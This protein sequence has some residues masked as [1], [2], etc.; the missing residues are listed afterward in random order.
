LLCGGGESFRGDHY[1]ILVIDAPEDDMTQQWMRD[2]L[3]FLVDTEWKAI[4]DFDCNEH[5][6]QFFE[7]TGSVVKITLCDEFDDMSDFNMQN[8]NQLQRL[9]DDIQHSAKQPSWIFVNGRGAEQSYSLSQWNKKRA[10]GFKKAVHFFSSEF[11]P[12]RTTVVFLLFSSD[13]SDILL[14]AVDEFCTLFPDQWMCVVQNDDIRQKLTDSV[15]ESDERIVVGMPWC[16]I[17]ES[18]ARL[19]TPE[20]TRACEIPTS[21]GVRVTL[22]NSMLNRLPDIEV[23]GCSEC[24]MDY[25]RCDKQE[26]EKL[27]KT[28][29]IKFYRGE[30]PTWWNFWFK[31]QVCEREIHNDLSRMVDRALRSSSDHDFV[32]RVRVY[33][34]PGAGGTTS[35][36]HILWTLRK[37]YRV[38]IIRICSDRLSSE[39]I[40]QLV[41]QIMEYRNYKE[42]A[43][44]NARPV[45]LL[46]DNP[47]EETES[48]LLSETNERA[49]SMVKPGDQHGV[50]CVFLEC[51]HLT[52]I[53]TSDSTNDLNY[54]SLKHELS[55][56]EIAWFNDK[57]QTLQE[58]F[59]ARMANSVNPE[60]LISFN[61]LKSNFN[62]DFISKTVGALVDAITSEKERTLLK[63]I[64]LLNSFD[65]RP[66]P[67]AAFDEMMSSG[68]PF[69]Q[70]KKK[71]TYSHWENE[72]SD[73]FRV[74][75][76]LKTTTHGTQGL[77]NTNALLA[78]ES[79]EAL[80]NTSTGKETI[81]DT[82][83]EFFK[84]SVFGVVSQSVKHLL[85]IVKDVLKKRQHLP[86]GE[87]TEFSPMILHILQTES[88]EKAREV[89]EKG[90]ELT[91]DAF[92]AQQLSR[93][94]YIKLQNWSQASV[95][96]KSAIDQL[97]NNSS[98]LWDTYGRIF[99]K[100]LSYE[101]EMYKGGAKT[102]THDRL[103]EIIDL[104]LKG[105]EM[106][107][108]SQNANEQERNPNNFGYHGELDIICILINCMVCCDTFKHDNITYLRKL[109]L[110][111]EF[112]P[113]EF[114]FLTN[115]KGRDYM[116]ELKDLKAEVDAVLK[117]L[118]DEKI[119][120]KVDV[121]YFRL[122]PDNLV[123]LKAD[124]CYYFGEGPDE[125][126]TKMFEKDKC[127]YRQRQIFRLGGTNSK[128]IFELKEKGEQVLVKVSRY[129]Q[130]NILSGAASARDY[131]IAISTNLALT[132][133]NPEMWCQLINFETM[134][135]WSKR[136]YDTRQTLST[137]HKR[138]LIYL[139]PYLF[140]VMFNWPL[141]TRDNTTQI[142][143]PRVVKDALAQ[144]KVEFRIKYPYVRLK[145]EG[146]S[147]VEKETT[148]FFLASGIGMESIY[149]PEHVSLLPTV[150]F[151]QQPHIQ[152]KLRRFEGILESGG[153]FVNYRYGESVLNFPTSIHI[154][155]R[156]WWGKKVDFVIGFTW[157][158]PKA[159]G[160][161]LV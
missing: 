148:L 82:A 95:A 108:K 67:L 21:T 23:L 15:T 1:R 8:P 131:L 150:R 76:V 48:L 2:N 155:D 96:I 5:I 130:Q 73:E 65:S 122:P 24:D 30:P 154:E 83:L 115:V 142:V 80:R 68:L 126:P 59:D 101:Y 60:S 11:P 41:S 51:L 125:P 26:Q 112:I 152:K 102:L 136:L 103:I 78:K 47:D 49:K 129:I 54:V 16:H 118:E 56:G 34:Q 44:T 153:K 69:V 134:S 105:I 110:D 81:S 22:A 158:A 45:L 159:Y 12:G 18:V 141:D 113:S 10:R 27:K 151:W 91:K 3:N 6:Y 77:C 40:D 140:M 19:Q 93:L 37:Y 31:T 149:T 116:R 109:L 133:I 135:Q 62:K 63:Y 97:S 35:A 99:E 139:E 52:H 114:R 64:S 161:K 92:V 32:D 7:S 146:R 157:A 84:C 13:I 100:Q 106:F 17:N 132:S 137:T 124:L 145:T 71:T 98:Y 94:L 144:W 29:E 117:R 147:H 46:L 43:Q 111:K 39:R 123:K 138:T 87:Y 28:E 160:M 128:S 156:S 50:F 66:V 33:H 55:Q 127:A 79:L 53:S 86:S 119:E 36:M 104:G 143:A 20:K 38:G 120:L 58:E 61:I 89:L 88:S 25:E 70:K 74:L 72:L 85:D 14:K 9:V 57:G 75:V 42:D 90:Y 4:F 121:K 107:Q